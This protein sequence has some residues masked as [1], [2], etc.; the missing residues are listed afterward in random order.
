L[1]SNYRKIDF[2]L[3]YNVTLLH[4][5]F[6]SIINCISIRRVECLWH[7]YR[8]LAIGSLLCPNFPPS[9]SGLRVW[10]CHKVWCLNNLAR[11]IMQMDH[12]MNISGKCNQ[13]ADLGKTLFDY[14]NEFID[15]FK[16]SSI[17]NIELLFSSTD[18]HFLLICIRSGLHNI[19]LNL[20]LNISP[21]YNFQRLPQ[22]NQHNILIYRSIR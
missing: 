2:K 20:N 15:D 7:L 19:L 8:Q 16:Y 14:L 11:F 9:L 13:G 18:D 17:W 6:P 3:N 12:L 10:Y 5:V 4:K 1:L 21:I 22:T